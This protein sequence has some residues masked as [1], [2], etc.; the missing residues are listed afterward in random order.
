M[1]DSERKEDLKNMRAYVK[2]LKKLPKATHALFVRAGIITEKG[3]LRK[4]YRPT[5]I[6]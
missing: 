3:N 6:K 5:Y 4:P 2:R 1:T